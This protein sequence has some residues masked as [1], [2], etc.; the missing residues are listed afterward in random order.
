MRKLVLLITNSLDNTLKFQQ[1]LAER[2]IENV[3]GPAHKIKS[4]LKPG[5]NWDLVIFESHGP[6][7]A[8]LDEVI[9][10]VEEHRSP[11]LLIVEED[12]APQVQ[13]PTLV[14]SDFAVTDAGKKECAAR[15]MRLLG[16]GASTASSDLVTVG[17]MTVNL[18][19]Y[20]V[21]IADEPL[22]LTY[23]EYALLAFF[24]QHPNRTFPRDELLRN[25]WGFDYYGGSRTVD[26][27]VRRIRSKLGPSL[28]HHLETVRGVGYMWSV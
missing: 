10:L 5:V 17:N 6:T 28:A 20:Q 7:K 24:V 26:V 27:H 8:Y 4:L 1:L 13:L 2:S 22:E 15:V 9:A 18:Q 3:T 11:L 23:L 16:D 19:A 25:V 21:T 14:E 12:D